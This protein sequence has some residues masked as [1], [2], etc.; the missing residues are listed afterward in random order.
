M[1]RPRCR[2]SALTHANHRSRC[3]ARV[4]QITDGKPIENPARARSFSFDR[5]DPIRTRSRSFLGPPTRTEDVMRRTL[6]LA[7]AATTASCMVGDPATD[8]D[9]TG[10]VSGAAPTITLRTAIGGKYV[11]AENGGGGDL[12]ANR[13]AASTWETFTL[14]DLNGGALTSGDLV[15]LAALDGHFLCA[16]QGGGGIVNATRTAAQD[17]ETFRVVKV[18][19]S[20][21]IKAGDQIALQTKTKGQYLSALNGG[22]GGIV[23]DRGSISGWEA[24]VVGGNLGGGGGGGTPP[25]TRLRITSNC[26]QPIPPSV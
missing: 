15:T 9:L 22:G 18:G 12:H 1:A 6:A 13:D 24:F 3:L 11:A 14:R 23:A 26:A 20:G 10:A 2:T 4:R 8:P 16:E 5:R 7:F 21:A 25:P 19:G 17:W